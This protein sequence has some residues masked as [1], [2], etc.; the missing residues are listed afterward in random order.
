[1]IR[2]YILALLSFQQLADSRLVLQTGTDSIS[3][4][5]GS[6]E[7]TADRAQEQNAGCILRYV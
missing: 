1:M 3:K 5:S 7:E 4:F 6:I 2:K